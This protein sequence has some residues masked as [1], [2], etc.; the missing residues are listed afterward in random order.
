MET[1]SWGAYSG[2]GTLDNYQLWI[3]PFLFSGPDLSPPDYN[4]GLP[5]KTSTS[6]VIVRGWDLLPGDHL[7]Y[8][9][10]V[11]AAG[12]L[13]GCTSA[14]LMEIGATG[15][16]WNGTTGVLTPGTP[17]SKFNKDGYWVVSGTPHATTAW[18]AWHQAND[19]SHGGAYAP[20]AGVTLDDYSATA[21]SGYTFAGGYTPSGVALAWKQGNTNPYFDLPIFD[22]VTFK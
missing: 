16:S 22:G 3:S 15:G 1:F 17:D 9:V 4:L 13:L 14:S 6:R 21:P 18:E 7:L 19:T 2:G 10:A 12:T 8:A 11:D 5:S 20:L